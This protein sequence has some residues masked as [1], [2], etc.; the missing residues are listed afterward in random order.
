[1]KDI[2]KRQQKLPSSETPKCGETLLKEKGWS[3][4]VNSSG[5]FESSQNA[6]V[7]T[8]PKTR[9]SLSWPMATNLEYYRQY[10]DENRSNSTIIQNGNTNTHTNQVLR[11]ATDPSNNLNILFRVNYSNNQKKRMN[12]GRK[13]ETVGQETLEMPSKLCLS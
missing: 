5:H 3:S 1:M 2:Q 12:A 10:T 8:A 13:K 7:E 11:E 9:H 6:C 4:Q